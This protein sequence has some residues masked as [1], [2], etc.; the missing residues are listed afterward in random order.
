MHGKTQDN[1]DKNDDAWMAV[2]TAAAASTVQTAAPSLSSAVDMIEEDGEHEK[3]RAATKIERK[4]EGRGGGARG[5][6]GGGGG[7]E[8]S[9]DAPDSWTKVAQN[10]K[11]LFFC[12]CC[13]CCL[14]LC[15]AFVSPCCP[16]W[17]LQDVLLQ[18]VH[19]CNA[20]F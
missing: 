19:A 1:G 6:G 11:P 17:M 9:K 13:S 18:I 15:S 7:G 8:S 16:R 12:C 3:V 4:Q 5:G 20:D 14:S 10:L 2:A